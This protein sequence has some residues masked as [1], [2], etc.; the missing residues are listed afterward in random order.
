V[1]EQRAA[2]KAGEHEHTDEQ[3]AVAA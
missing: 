1:R 2:A 3:A